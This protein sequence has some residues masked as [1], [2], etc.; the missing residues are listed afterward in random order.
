MFAAT[1]KVIVVTIAHEVPVYTLFNLAFEVPT[2]PDKPF[3]QLYHFFPL[4]G[5][6]GG[7]TSLFLIFIDSSHVYG[8]G[9]G[10]LR[11]VLITTTP[12]SSLYRMSQLLPV[13]DRSDH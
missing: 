13:T 5:G 11:P 9:V 1:G 3:Q 12:R 7:G 10:A 6:G 8:H 4:G 2:T